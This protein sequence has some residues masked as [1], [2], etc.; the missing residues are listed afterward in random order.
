[1]K[2]QTPKF[3]QISQNE[4]KFDY[5]GQRFILE[6]G[7]VG[8][9]GLGRCIRL[10]QLDGLKKEFIKCIGWTK[11]DNH[12]GPGKD[13]LTTDIIKMETSKLFAVKYIEKLLK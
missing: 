13:C 1:M 9:F 12:G 2:K 7:K 6:E 3:E 5:L 11:S 4:I 8:V 10:Y